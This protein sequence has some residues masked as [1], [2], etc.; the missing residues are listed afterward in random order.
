MASDSLKHQEVTLHSVMTGSTISSTEAT[1][2]TYN[3]RK[4]SD[5]NLLIFVFGI[6]DTDFRGNIVINS[7]AWSTGRSFHFTGNHGSSLENR[8]SVDGT[9]V[10]DT[11]IKLKT[12]GSSAFTR[13]SCL[14]LK[15]TF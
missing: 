7:G 12:G 15:L 10:S 9:Y 14:G 11:S 1:Y 4:F 13:V 3:G 8:S 2:N 5:Y 6:G